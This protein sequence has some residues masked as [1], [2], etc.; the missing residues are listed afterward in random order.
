MQRIHLKNLLKAI[1]EKLDAVSDQPGSI[2]MKELFS[3]AGLFKLYFLI[4]Q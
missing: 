2:F 3:H 1:S 4:W